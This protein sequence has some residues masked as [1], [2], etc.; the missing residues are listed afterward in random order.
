M[1]LNKTGWWFQIFF[2]FTP[3]WGIQFDY[4]IFFQMGW[5]HQLEKIFESESY[6]PQMKTGFRMP[7]WTKRWAGLTCGYFRCVIRVEWTGWSFFLERAV[8]LDSY[9]ILIYIRHVNFNYYINIY[10]LLSIPHVY[11]MHLYMFILDIIISTYV[12]CVCNHM[13]IFI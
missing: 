11:H 6:V 3:T 10:L 9:N 8:D 12:S 1:E 13:F 4:K 5:N 7:S 2:V